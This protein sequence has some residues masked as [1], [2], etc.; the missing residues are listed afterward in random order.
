M[1]IKNKLSEKNYNYIVLLL[2]DSLL[3]LFFCK[4]FLISNSIVSIK[5][6]ILSI[7]ILIFWIII[8]YILGS[9]LDQNKKLFNAFF[10]LIF[11][12]S[13]AIILYLP[14]IVF[15]TFNYPL[16][17]ISSIIYYFIK[18]NFLSFW[19]HFLIFTLNTFINKKGLIWL[20]IGDPITLKNL[21]IEC[22]KS[23]FK[24]KIILY[25]NK[26]YFKY[27]GIIIDDNFKNLKPAKYENTILLSNWLGKYLQKY[28]VDL[29]N[30]LF[31]LDNLLSISH[32]SMQMRIKDVSERLIA[33]IL[34]II[35]IPL[36]FI[37]SIFIFFEDGLPIFYKQTRNGIFNKVIKITKL[38]TMKSN[39]EIDGIQWS[40][41]ND[42]RITN[43]GRF[44]RR[45]RFDELP[46]LISVIKGE[47]SLIGPRP[48]RPEID[49]FLSKDIN[50]Y[51]IRYNLKP[52]LSGWAQVNYP[53][54]A[55]LQD[56]KNKFSYDLYYIKNFSNLLDIRILFMTIKLVF[57]AKG[58]IA[59][60]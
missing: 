41:K 54:G 50:N 15:F 39:A 8:N 46:Q 19:L 3:F 29:I 33:I 11:N 17:N 48:E 37:S 9:Y 22:E 10:K 20:F 24:T 60:K 42:A 30:N 38:R 6:I 1:R 13:F 4:S 34:L 56:A 25:E 35:V 31:F 40:K 28:P 55:S 47:M 51:F 32:N 44:I 36:I 16:E 58:A 59:K 21:I 7:F 27:D 2:L 53:Y 52:G 12:Y 45:V 18:L 5:N 57:N 14:F 43:V 23:K 49:E 26:N